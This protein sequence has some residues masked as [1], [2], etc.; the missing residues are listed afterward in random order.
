M[1]TAK[2][3]VHIYNKSTLT[4][5]SVKVK[6]QN[7]RQLSA[8]SFVRCVNCKSEDGQVAVETHRDQVK[9]LSRMFLI[10][11]GD[12]S[13][14]QTSEIGK[15]HFLQLSNC[16]SEISTNLERFFVNKNMSQWWSSVVTHVTAINPG[17][18]NFLSL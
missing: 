11:T 3:H 18:D 6:R 4:I 12:D 8:L 17:V 16:E 14:K 1:K 15:R 7:N 9:T 10:A 5:F 13:G 2:R